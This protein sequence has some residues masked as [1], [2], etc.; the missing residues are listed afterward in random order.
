MPTGYGWV[1]S[2]MMDRAVD[3]LELT[4]AQVTSLPGVQEAIREAFHNELLERCVEI[5]DEERGYTDDDVD[6]AREAWEDLQGEEDDL[7]EIIV[8]SWGYGE[9]FRDGDV[10]AFGRIKFK[11]DEV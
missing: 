3:R 8:F 11:L 9:V 6:N 10:L 4:L 1:T 5:R 2:D 7:S